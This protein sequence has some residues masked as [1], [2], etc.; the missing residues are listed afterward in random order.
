MSEERYQKSFPVGRRG[1]LCR[2]LI[3]AQIGCPNVRDLGPQFLVREG[4]RVR[5]RKAPILAR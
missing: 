2:G 1:H 4:R 5:V 3:L